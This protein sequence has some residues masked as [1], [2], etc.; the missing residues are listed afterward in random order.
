MTR[1]SNNVKIKPTYQFIRYDIRPSSGLTNDESDYL[2]ACVSKLQAHPNVAEVAIA[3]ELPAGQQDPRGTGKHAHIGIRFHRPVRT[4]KVPIL[5]VSAYAKECG[6]SFHAV[7]VVTSELWSNSQYW[8]MGYIQ[9]DG[10]AH[11]K[12]RDYSMFWYDHERVMR[13]QKVRVNSII[14]NTLEDEVINWWL[15]NYDKIRKDLKKIRP[16][17]DRISFIDVLAHLLCTTKCAF[18]LTRNVNNRAFYASC[19]LKYFDECRDTL[20]KTGEYDQAMTEIDIREKYPVGGL[21]SWAVPSVVPPG[22]DH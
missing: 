2:D 7:K 4:D 11:G 5:K 17:K 16:C 6:W 3:F 1:K 12:V 13:Q 20:S 21:H 14:C 18:K 8:K 15:G 9:K 10:E 22:E 19:T